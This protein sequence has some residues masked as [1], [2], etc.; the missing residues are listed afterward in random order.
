MS[1]SVTLVYQLG[2]SV[3]L[4]GCQIVNRIYLIGCLSISDQYFYYLDFF[5]ITKSVRLENRTED[6]SHFLLYGTRL[7]EEHDE[8]LKQEE[9]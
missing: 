2:Q 1:D 5:P 8:V 7:N 9:E 3:H 6:F 4:P